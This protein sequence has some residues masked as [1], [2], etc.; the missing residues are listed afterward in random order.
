MDRMWNRVMKPLPMNPIPKRPEGMMSPVDWGN[1]SWLVIRLDDGG[2]GD[3]V[4]VT[5]HL[6]AFDA[7]VQSGVDGCRDSKQA[8]PAGRFS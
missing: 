1:P 8:P 6:S 2:Q 4:N 7:S 5:R 3:E